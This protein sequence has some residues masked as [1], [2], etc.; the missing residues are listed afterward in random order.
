MYSIWAYLERK[1]QLYLCCNPSPVTIVFVYLCICTFLYLHICTFLYLYSCVFVCFF[2]AYL[3]R[4]SQL[5]LCCKQSRVTNCQH[6]ISSSWALSSNF[7]N[8]YHTCLQNNKILEKYTK[9]CIDNWWA[10]FTVFW[11]TIEVLIKLMWP[12]FDGKSCCF[13]FKRARQMWLN[14]RHKIGFNLPELTKL[15]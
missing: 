3:D 2:W 5:S 7:L 13:K 11:Q 6:P 4:K 8:K 9:L 15:N 12:L 10:H 14:F 1:S